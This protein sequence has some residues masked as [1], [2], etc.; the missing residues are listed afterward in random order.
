MAQPTETDR[1]G[2]VDTIADECI[3]VRMR[4]LNRVVT[5]IFDEALRP[6]G[7]KVSQLNILVATARMGIARPAEVCDRLKLDTST[8]KANGWLKVVSDEDGRT[9][10]FRLTA[11]GNRLLQ[12]AKR[13]WEQAQAEATKLL[14]D[15]AVLEIGN[16]VA[17]MRTRQITSP[18]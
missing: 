1:K 13:K 11:K 18:A 4:M 3:A 7:L 15:P 14:G 12:R 5:N 6:L 10:P 8:L 2:L 9:Q 16:A 17:R